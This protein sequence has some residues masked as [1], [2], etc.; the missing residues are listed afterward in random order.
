MHGT[1]IA[2]LNFHSSLL[3]PLFSLSLSLSVFADH[4][5]QATHCSIFN[6]HFFTFLVFHFS[7]FLTTCFSFIHCA[8]Q[9][10]YSALIHIPYSI[11]F[12][13][14]SSMFISHSPLTPLHCSL[15]ITNFSFLTTLMFLQF[16]LLNYPY[17]SFL[18]AHSYTVN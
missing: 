12:N 1:P 13:A 10:R 15:L 4:S 17:F 7:S 6:P 18:I 8:Y 3:S 11:L 5:L 2:P 16:T 9:T 14:Q